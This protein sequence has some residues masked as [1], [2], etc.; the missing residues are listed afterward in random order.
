MPLSER[1]QR[2][3]EEIEKNLHQDDPALGRSVGMSRTGNT[4]RIRLGTLIFLSGFGLLIGFFISGAVLVGVLAFGAMVTGIFIAVTAAGATV[5]SKRRA[6]K[7]RLTQA[8]TEW[9][10]RIRQ[11]YRRR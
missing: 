11:R 8:V 3:L 2:I 6:G 7:E 9:E 10:R 4:R 5:S 1:E